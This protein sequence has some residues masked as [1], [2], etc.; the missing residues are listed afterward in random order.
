MFLSYLPSELQS[1]IKQVDKKATAGSMSTSITSSADK[2]WL[3]SEVEVDGTTT[4]VYADEGEQ[5]EYWRTVKD[6][7]AAADRKKYLSNGSSGLRR[8][9]LLAPDVDNPNHFK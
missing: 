5:Y 4:A 1:V 8:R 9:R 6:G 2:L 3:L 7:T